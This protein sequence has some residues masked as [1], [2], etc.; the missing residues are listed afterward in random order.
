MCVGPKEASAVITERG[1][2][3]VVRYRGPGVQEPASLTATETGF[4][5]R[6]DTAHTADV[7][8]EADLR[9]MHAPRSGCFRE[10]AMIA[11]AYSV[12]GRHDESR[13]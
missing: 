4:T 12:R 3:T 7:L 9:H 8:A 2:A 13:R 5:L 1:G 6:E 10:V 11:H